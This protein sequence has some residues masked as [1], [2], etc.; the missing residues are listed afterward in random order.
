MTEL[1]LIIVMIVL[2][3]AVVAD[4]CAGNFDAMSLWVICVVCLSLVYMEFTGC[5]DVATYVYCV[6]SMR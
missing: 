3:F 6:E 2:I 4:G 1:C 5:P